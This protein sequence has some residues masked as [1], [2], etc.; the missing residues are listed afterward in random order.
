MTAYFA[1]A[2]R[3]APTFKTGGWAGRNLLVLGAAGG[4]G[5]AAVEVGKALGAT[6]FAGAPGDAVADHRKA[7]ADHAVDIG[8][9]GWHAKV[10]NIAPKGVDIVFDAIGGDSIYS[11]LRC[12]K[13]GGALL[14]VG[15][16]T[17]IPSVSL[18]HLLQRNVSVLGVGAPARTTT[19]VVGAGPRHRAP[20]RA[21]QVYSSSLQ[22]PEQLEDS[23]QKIVT[24]W[25]EGRAQPDATTA[26][27]PGG[28]VSLRRGPGRGRGAAATG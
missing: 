9:R 13:I 17:K 23:A 3:A 16:A 4:V 15:F 8:P 1:L 19:V 25:G 27:R 26:P 21:A 18:E 24:L 22:F 12:L 28:T 2:Q 11:T 10:L 20:R 5:A 7:E 6:V 14:S